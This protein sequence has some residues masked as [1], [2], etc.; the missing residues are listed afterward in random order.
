M[1][2]TWNESE[3]YCQEFG[4]NLAAITSSA[5]HEIAKSV[6]ET[7]DNEENCWIGLY[8]NDNASEYKWSDG[9]DINFGFNS[10]GT[11]TT[12]VYPWYSS[13]PNK[14]GDCIEMW[15]DKDY[16]WNDRSCQ[17]LLYPVCNY[18]M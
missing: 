3:A 18:G 12:G 4:S 6:C 8:H 2:L 13:E 10:D 5:A 11:P 1:T 16:D 17:D 15:D 14:T 7:K 9:S